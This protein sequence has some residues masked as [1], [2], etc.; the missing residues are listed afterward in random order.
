MVY[1]VFSKQASQ[2]ER[3]EAMLTVQ[4]IKSAA[5]ER[6]GLVEYDDQ[7][8]DLCVWVATIDD[9]SIV[10]DAIMGWDGYT[11]LVKLTDVD[12]GRLYYLVP[13]VYF[14]GDGDMVLAAAGSLEA[15]QAW[16][17]DYNMARDEG[18]GEA[19]VY[20]WAGHELVDMP[21]ELYVLETYGLVDKN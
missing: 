2:K 3:K 12:G 18:S 4:K 9:V 19:V 10:I 21:A 8:E 6:Q 17:K 7:P 13:T 20:W 11:H 5:W 1:I 16:A 15:A 14:V